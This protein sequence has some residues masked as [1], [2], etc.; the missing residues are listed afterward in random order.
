MNE[1]IKKFASKLGF[2]LVSIIPAEPTKEDEKYLNDIEIRLTDFGNCI[3]D[4]NKTFEI[5]T[6]Y[7]RAP[8]VM[9]NH[10]F[11]ATRLPSG[12]YLYRLQAGDFNQTNKMILLK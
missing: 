12:I 11:D 3:K 6:R 9:L 4:D 2:H 10:D 5:Q 1:E 8:E 7:Y